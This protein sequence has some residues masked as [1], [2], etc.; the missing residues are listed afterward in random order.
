[1]DFDQ[2][3]RINH[4]YHYHLRNSNSNY[5]C[6]GCSV[7]DPRAQA[8]PE[9]HRCDKHQAEQVAMEEAGGLTKGF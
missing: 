3:R 9:E 2:E 7:R 4:G 5:D 8:T 1:V 6:G